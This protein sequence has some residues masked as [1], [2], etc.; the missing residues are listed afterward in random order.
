[1]EPWSHGINVLIRDNRGLAFSEVMWAYGKMVATRVP[2]E[3]PQNEGHLPCQHLDLRCPASRTVRNTSLW[4]KPPS[5]WSLVMV[6]QADW[7]RKESKWTC[8]RSDLKWILKNH[9]FWEEKVTWRALNMLSLN[10]VL[11]ELSQDFC[12][13]F[14]VIIEPWEMWELSSWFSH[15]LADCCGQTT[16]AQVGAQAVHPN[17]MCLEWVL[18]EASSTPEIPD[19]DRFSGLRILG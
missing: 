16:Q 19:S 8:F 2:G 11:G 13:R 5:L 6:A 4:F 12:V 17:R 10:H 15:E 9:L 7:H 14:T 1:M 18:S 3:G